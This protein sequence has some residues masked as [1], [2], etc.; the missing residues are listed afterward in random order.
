MK[1]KLTDGKI[2]YF[3]Q[4]HW[5]LGDSTNYSVEQGYKDIIYITGTTEVTENDTNVFVGIPIH[6]DTND[7]IKFKRGMAYK[8]RSDSYYMAYQ[9]YLELG[10]TDEADQAK[11]QWISEINKIESELPYIK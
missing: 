11:Q 7:D 6:V 8:A 2:N 1:A 3:V 9:K 5:L 4:P 10:S